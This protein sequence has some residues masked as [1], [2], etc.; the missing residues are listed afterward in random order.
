MLAAAPYLSVVVTSR[1]DN[2]G[3][4]LLARFQTFVDVLLDQCERHQL[5]AELIIVE[6][7][8]PLDRPRLAEVL[9]WPTRHEVC[10]VRFL[11]VPPALHRQFP[12]HSGLPLFQMLA[13]NVGIRRARGEFI[14]CT[15]IDLLFA[16][17]LIAWLGQRPLRRGRLYRID[18]HDVAAGVTTL[19]TTEER[20][21]YCR[22]NLLRVNAREGTFPVEGDGQRMLQENDIASPDWGLSFQEGWQ[23]VSN[24]GPERVRWVC[25]PATFT[26][27]S[28]EAR[29]LRVRMEVEPAPACAPFLL[30]VCRPD[31]T[32][33]AEHRIVTRQ[34]LRFDLPVRAEVTERFILQ[35]CDP[36]TRQIRRT[37]FD[38]LFRVFEG[39]SVV[40]ATDESG[41]PPAPQ[42]DHV[43]RRLLR[44]RGPIEVPPA[45]MPLAFGTGFYTLECEQGHPFRWAG[46]KSELCLQTPADGPR[47][48]QLLVEPGPA[49]AGQV[50]QFCLSTLEG[51]V[52]AQAPLAQ[53]QWIDA[54]LPLE[55]GAIHTLV[56]QVEPEPKPIGND[57]RSLAFRLWHC[58]WGEVAQR[59]PTDDPTRNCI[60][61][62]PLAGTSFRAFLRRLRGAI[63]R[64]WSRGPGVAAS[65]PASTEA[66]TPVSI[67][68]P[69]FPPTHVNE[70]VWLH[71]NASGDFTLMAR[72]HWL[73]LRGYPEFPI[74][75]MHLDS[76][77][78]WMAYHSGLT[79]EV[80]ADPL[81]VYHIEH[82]GGWTPET[83]AN[84]YRRL[85]ER[86]VPMLTYEQLVRWA[87]EM[88]RM[89]RPLIF[90]QDNWGLAYEDLPETILG[91]E[92][93]TAP[94]RVWQ[95]APAEPLSF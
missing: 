13:K 61:R 85:Q 75:S 94:A 39:M 74:Y 63:K 65:V 25:G 40:A 27:R 82:G 12:N 2:H 89:D 19:S 3:E 17:E 32:I 45:T 41:G 15:N 59:A 47:I 57:P 8:P 91:R 49:Y 7:N 79:E 24:D 20:L 43:A 68:P 6:W 31:E 80:L 18:R 21:A 73:M 51:K 90:N 11:E 66:P 1:H 76:L 54:V 62:G 93:E 22:A 38:L 26:L 95:H 36:E 16:E 77:L 9:R 35:V 58:G 64:P 46:A 33:L 88:R 14:L 55:G 37:P 84:L 4:G 71:T 42:T 30:Q 52:L 10:P 78:C 29:T 5:P 92:D 69:A 28:P 87:I 83:S 53:R 60:V 56:L 70:P 34:F 48:L 23:A 81:R 67:E 86:G 50:V 44:K 72:E